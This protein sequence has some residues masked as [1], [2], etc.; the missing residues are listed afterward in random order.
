MRIVFLATLFA[1]LCLIA[2]AQEPVSISSLNTASIGQTVVVAGEITEFTASRSERAPNSFQ[3]KD[4]TGQIRVAIWPD[5]FGQIANS[6]E[7]KAGAK[8]TV[9]ARASE[10]RS[11]VELHV[12]AAGDVAIGAAKLGPTSPA[13]TVA[14]GAQATSAPAS[15]GN[16][17]C[18]SAPAAASAAPV[19]VTIDK[20]TK[21]TMGQFVTFLGTVASVRKPTSDTAPYIVKITEGA[22]SIDVVFWQT[23]VDKMTDSQKPNMGDRV[24]I[25]GKV[26]EHRGNLQVRVDDPK[27]LQTRRSAPD[28]VPEASVSATTAPVSAARPIKLGEIASAATGERVRLAGKVQTIKPIR[29]GRELVLSDNGTTARVLLWDT[30]EGMNPKTRSLAPAQSLELQ[31]KVADAA[32]QK[33]L[34]VERPEEILSIQ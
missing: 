15:T 33:A 18:Q 9:R 11:Q 23:S 26:N 4:S 5:V 22:N 8:V 27:G 21:E 24:R 31:G 16:I 32:G 17:F 14:T 34:V 28:V 3:L 12:N 25:T 30:A 7:L 29:A 2:S 1:V 10:F 13:K 6:A 19:E 20:I